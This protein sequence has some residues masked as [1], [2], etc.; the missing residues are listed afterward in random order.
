MQ[1]LN[2]TPLKAPFA[3]PWRDLKTAFNFVHKMRNKFKKAT[4]T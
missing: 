2:P 3:L 1:Q 4:I